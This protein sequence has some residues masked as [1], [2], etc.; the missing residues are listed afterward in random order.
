VDFM[1]PPGDSRPGRTRPF[2]DGRPMTGTEDQP[3]TATRAGPLRGVVDVPGDKSISHRALILGALAEGDTRISGLL[4]GHDVLHTAEALR[5]L[6]VDIT[7]EADGVWTVRGE[8]RAA[9]REPVLPLDFGNSGTGARL[10]MGAI[11]GSPLTATFI[12]DASLSARPMGR[13]LEP[14]EK[15]GAR[16]LCR[17]GGRLPLTL[18]G[19]PDLRAITYETP[20]PSAQVKSAILLAGLGARG[21]TTV[22][23]PRASRD[24]TERML[25]SFGADLSVESVPGDGR[26][27]TLRGGARL[28]GRD[29]DVPGDPSSAAFV[30]AAALITPGSDV[31]VTGVLTNPLRAGLFATLIEMG[32]D[33]AFLDEREVGGELVADIRARHSALRAADPPPERAPSMIDEYP[34][35]AAVA[36]FADGETMMRGVGELRVKETD[37]IAAMVEGLRAC[38]VETNQGE[39]WFSVVGGGGAPPGGGRVRVC[40]DHRIA[41]SFLTLGLGAERPVTIDAGQMIATSFPGFQELMARIGARIEPGP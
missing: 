19:D 28:L 3:L 11:A 16:A 38:G 36:A 5:R 10:T 20:K 32:A 27:I 24:H 41:M 14:L 39:D 4:E 29:V 37:R 23:E 21:E 8:G 35:L 22:I 13:V 12:G 2:A 1:E 31:T 9:L 17:S 26:R 34:I 30:L 18:R 33:I 7:R 25:A 15:M 6:G 40:D